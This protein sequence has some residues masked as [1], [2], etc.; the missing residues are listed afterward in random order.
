MKPNG[1]KLP[2]DFNGK[3]TARQMRYLGVNAVVEINRVGYPSKFLM[4]DFI[5]RYRCIAFDQPQL[6][7]ESL[8]SRQVCTN[9][10]NVAGGDLATGWFNDLDVQMGKTK[11]GRLACYGH[12]DGYGRYAPLWPLWPAMACYS[13]SGA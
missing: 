1:T 8:G 3:F 13:H 5:R 12:Y 2:D 11:V 6:L 4:K 9:L 7:A 10:M